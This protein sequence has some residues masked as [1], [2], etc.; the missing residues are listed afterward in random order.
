VKIDSIVFTD[1]T[2]LVDGA[3]GQILDASTY[4]V[5]KINAALGANPSDVMTT[6]HGWSNDD[7]I[8]YSSLL[9]VV[10]TTAPAGTGM[11]HIDSAGYA[12]FANNNETLDQQ[13][14]DVE[15]ALSHLGANG[16]HEAGIAVKW[17]GVGADAN[18]S[19]VFITGNHASPTDATHDQLIKIVG[20]DSSQVQIAAGLVVHS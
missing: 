20:V 11:A 10:Q 19:Y 3:G 7:V 13:I 18:N 4:D 17:D 14:M 15:A 9:K 16:S 2:I 1:D 8:Q 6:L 5:F 12:T